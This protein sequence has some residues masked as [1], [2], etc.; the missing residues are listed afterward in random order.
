MSLYTVLWFFTLKRNLV[1][2]RRAIKNKQRI[3]TAHVS[4]GTQRF[5]TAYTR[6]V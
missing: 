2:A 3:E 5:K 4:S 1:K 6:A